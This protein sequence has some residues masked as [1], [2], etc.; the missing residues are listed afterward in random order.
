MNDKG[1]IFTKEVEAPDW[2]VTVENGSTYPLYMFTKEVLRYWY[3]FLKAQS[4]SIRRQ[5]LKR[6]IGERT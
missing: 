5:P 6:L 4:I 1:D 2:V 3:N